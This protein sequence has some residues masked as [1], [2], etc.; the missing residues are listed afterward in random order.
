[1]QTRVYEKVSYEAISIG[2]I[3]L[4]ICARSF[5][6][7]KQI[8]MHIVSSLCMMLRRVVLYAL[9]NFVEPYEISKTGLVL[10]QCTFKREAYLNDA[11]S[12][13][14][15]EIVELTSTASAI[16]LRNALGAF[17]S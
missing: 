10:M 1:M 4:I 16:L 12:P 2:Y 6:F 13:Y 7:R 3:N 11:V 15:Y 8:S 9:F 14:F 17:F 5:G